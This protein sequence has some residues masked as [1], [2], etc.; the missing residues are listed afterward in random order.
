ML[1]TVR[2]K[3]SFST[4]FLHKF[5]LSKILAI[6]LFNWKFCCLLIACCCCDKGNYGKEQKW[7]QRKVRPHIDPYIL[8]K[9]FW[10][11]QSHSKRIEQRTKSSHRFLFLFFTYENEFKV[12]FLI[13][14]NNSRKKLF[15]TE[16][17]L[18]T[19]CVCVLCSYFCI[20]QIITKG[21]KK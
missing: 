2:V 5:C 1:L 6:F 3:L 13:D 12:I 10:G 15:M 7:R 17:F 16:M 21:E 14:N 11:F 9:L 4:L 20:L 19:L 8:I 18:S